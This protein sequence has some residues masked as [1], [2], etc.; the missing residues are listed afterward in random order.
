DSFS[1][2]SA[3]RRSLHSSPTRRSSDLGVTIATALASALSRR[4]V[5]RDVAMTGEITLRGRVL[6]IGGVKEKLLGAHRAGI[7]HVILPAENAVELEDL[8]EDVRAELTVHPV[9]DLGEVLAIALLPPGEARPAREA[10]PGDRPAP[11]GVLHA[12]PARSASK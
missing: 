11:P 1:G 4:R 9:S 10:P 6:P 7:Q 12:G 3:P 2:D 8:P 5:R